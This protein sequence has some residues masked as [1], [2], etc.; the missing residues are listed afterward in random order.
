M[1][2]LT[3]KNAFSP[4][5]PEPTPPKQP[6]RLRRLDDGWRCLVMRYWPRGVPRGQVDFNWPDL[7]PSAELIDA[8]LHGA[9]PWRTF[10]ARYKAEMKGQR[11]FLRLLRHLDQGGQR[12]TLLCAC[13][14]PAKCHRSL[15]ADLIQPSQ[16][17][18]LLRRSRLARAL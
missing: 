16:P 2:V 8:Y 14:D 15:L 17:K 13:A 1:P 4:R 5:S 3:A 18:R 7:A 12:L 9:M 6:L 10:A 11:S